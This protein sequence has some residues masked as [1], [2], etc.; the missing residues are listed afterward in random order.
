MEWTSEAR[1]RVIMELFNEYHRINIEQL[2]IELKIPV[3]TIEEDINVLLREGKI[4]KVSEHVITKKTS[5]SIEPSYDVRNAMNTVVKSKI[6]MKATELIEHGDV[7]LIDEGSTTA[8]MGNYFDYSKSFTVVTNS[9]SLIEAM[10]K[11]I[12]AYEYPLEVIFLGG[13]VSFDHKRV[14]GF[15]SESNVEFINADKVFITVDGFSAHGMTGHDQEKSVLSKEFIRRSRETVILADQSKI[16]R[17]LHF[18]IDKLDAVSCIITDCELPPELENLIIN[19]GI[20]WI[21]V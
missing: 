15:F 11:N 20:E 4:D 17:N 19:T 12:P 5:A 1:C 6:A 16:G 21:C 10:Q 3:E 18:N 2:S 7:I 9:F 8:Q 13:K 14:T